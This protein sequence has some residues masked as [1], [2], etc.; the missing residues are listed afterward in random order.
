[1]NLAWKLEW[2]WNTEDFKSSRFIW[3]KLFL[4]TF[5]QI[6][7]LFAI[8]LADQK[9]P[10][11]LWE[12][13]I[14]GY[15]TYLHPYDA[16]HLI[17]IWY[18]TKT[19]QWW[20]TINDG[21]KVDLYEINYNKKCWDSTLSTEE[22]TWCD[23]WDYK[24]IIVKQLHSL[25]LWQNWSN[26][27]ALSNPR[28]FMWNEAKKL[29]II[30][31]TLYKNDWKDYYN[32][33]DFYN[34]LFAINIDKDAWISENYRISHIDTTWIE[35]ERTKDCEQYS[36]ISKDPKCYK[37]IWWWEYCEPI[38][39]TYVPKYCYEWSSIW[40]YLVSRSYNYANSFIKRW[41][42]IENNIYSISD[43]KIW[44]NNL[45]N[46]VSKKEIELK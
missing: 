35:A 6:D 1:L 39:S 46:W 33:T 36:T 25:T 13:K 22:K 38:S 4:V 11:I 3:D 19:N 8:D 31:A 5:K 15:S 41:L 37:I 32:Y 44:I 17:W 14:P 34:W 7:P 43:N 40:E 16:N 24:W 23:K 42:W 21:I 29:L 30:P 27:E 45:I 20:G 18:N 10:K 2:I 9:N 28:M 26:S 12:L